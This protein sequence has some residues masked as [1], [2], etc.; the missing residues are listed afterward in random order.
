LPDR[1][2]AKTERLRIDGTGEF[3]HPLRRLPVTK[4]AGRIFALVSHKPSA[5]QR[6]LPMERLGHGNSGQP[7]LLPVACDASRHETCAKSLQRRQQVVE[8]PWNI[9]KLMI[10]YYININCYVFCIMYVRYYDFSKYLITVQY[11]HSKTFVL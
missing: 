10:K 4:R 7:V 8:R 9:P 1:H 2:G 6:T 5:V 11:C 3:V